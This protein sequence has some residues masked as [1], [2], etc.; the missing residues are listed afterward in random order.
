MS[1][2]KHFNGC[3]AIGYVVLILIRIPFHIG[4]HRMYFRV[5]GIFSQIISI[6]NTHRLLRQ[7]Q[8]FA[9][10]T[11]RALILYR[12]IGSIEAFFT[13]IHGHIAQTLAAIHRISTRRRVL[14]KP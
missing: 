8:D 2:L 13:Q 9:K 4:H 10:F 5:F 1:N 11:F 14:D 3:S 12:A 7:Q 6:Q